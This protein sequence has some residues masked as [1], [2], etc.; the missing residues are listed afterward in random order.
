MQCEF[1]QSRE[2][3]IHLTEIT[4]GVRT[5]THMCEQCAQEH[6]VGSKNYIPL[7]EL[8]SNL[9]AAGPKEEEAGRR[10]LRLDED[11]RLAR[12]AET[13][14]PAS[15]RLGVHLY[16]GSLQLGSDPNLDGGDHLNAQHRS[17]GLL[18]EATMVNATPPFLA[19]QA[20]DAGAHFR[21]GG[22]GYSGTTQ[23]SVVQN[24]SCQTGIPES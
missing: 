8:L 19:R 3:T 1:C 15:G 14:R 12:Q 23:S 13:P 11:S 4:D 17:P 20:L 5:E 18:P 22:P 9:L 16:V 2:A 21:K 10:T 6:G 24:S 7:N